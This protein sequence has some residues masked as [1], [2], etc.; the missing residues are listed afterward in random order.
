MT[1]F[2]VD[3][4]AFYFVAILVVKIPRKGAIYL[5]I[6]QLEIMLKIEIEH[7]TTIY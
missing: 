1:T 2:L 7:D 4:S 5:A 3:I 6:V